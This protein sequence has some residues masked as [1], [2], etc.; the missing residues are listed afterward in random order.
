MPFA[1]VV[2]DLAADAVDRRFTYR[3][4]DDLPV[5]VGDMVSAPF[6]PRTLEG[7]VV[8]VK[9]EPGMD[10]SRVRPLKSV[11]AAGAILPELIELAEWMKKRYN[12]R[13][14]DALRLMIPSEMRGAP[15][16]IRR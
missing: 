4:P 10:E 11:A 9:D 16:R 14:V 1:E 12:C 6:G 7:F 13:F 8:S 5:S 2:V 15:T 3:I